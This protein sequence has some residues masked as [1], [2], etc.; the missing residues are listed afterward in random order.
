MGGACT[1]YSQLTQ[2]QLIEGPPYFGAVVGRC[3]N[4]I[5]K[6]KFRIDDV[7]YQ[8]ATN[9]G[10]NALHGKNSQCYGFLQEV[11]SALGNLSYYPA[12]PCST[13]CSCSHALTTGLQRL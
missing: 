1:S 5:A 10:P 7:D 13:A 2:I 9:N 4:R 3:A 11:V 12:A 8:L 6:G